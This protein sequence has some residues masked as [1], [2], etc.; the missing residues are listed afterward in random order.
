MRVAELTFVI[1]VALHRGYP[2]RRRARRDVPGAS[3]VE[4]VK[5]W[6]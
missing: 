2:R 3:E 4:H 1:A 6:G 5:E